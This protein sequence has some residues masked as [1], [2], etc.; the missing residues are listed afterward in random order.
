M[1]ENSKLAIE[2]ARKVAMNVR[3]KM[4]E[5]FPIDE[6]RKT[7][8][9]LDLPHFGNWNEILAVLMPPAKYYI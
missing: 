7:F 2:S 5:Q 6:F 8:P 1:M 9:L 3:L 4:I